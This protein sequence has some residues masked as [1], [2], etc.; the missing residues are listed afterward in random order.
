M[1][2][3]RTRGDFATIAGK[4]AA[5]EE[6]AQEQ[7]RTLSPDHRREETHVMTEQI[8][9]RASDS[10]RARSGPSSARK[11]RAAGS[12]TADDPVFGAYIRDVSRHGLLTAEQERRMGRQLVECR[13]GYWREVLSYPPFVEAA[14]DLL[15]GLEDMDCPPEVLETFG[16]LREA[17]RGVRGSNRREAREGFE[18][19]L[20]EAAGRLAMLDTEC[21]GADRIA[22]DLELVEAGERRG[23]SMRVRLPRKGSRPFLEYVGRVRRAATALRLKRNEFARANLRLVIRIATRFKS[24]G[25][26]LQ[27]R[28]QEGNLG[29]MKAI[30]RFDPT[31][32][33]RFSTYGSWWIRHAIR[34]AVVNRGR[35]IRLPAHLQAL[36]ARLAKTRRELR[37]ALQRDPTT[38]ELAEAVDTPIEKVELVLDAMQLRPVSLD[39]RM[40]E[41]DDRSVGELLA[42]EVDRQPGEQLDLDEATQRLRGTLLTLAPMEQ[43]ILR[44]RFGLDGS[45]TRTLAEIGTQYSLSRER[46][47]QLQQKALNRV[48]KRL[49]T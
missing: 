44:Q 22:A 2:R 21:V 40:G 5:E 20:E 26:S 34:R 49:R 11:K 14:L 47:R 46:I 42:A 19:A 6:E 7:E 15:E 27:D 18:S 12:G 17:T 23:L 48:R 36:W 38:A 41:H 28:V 45:E 31:R 8:Q 25:L 4:I 10:V 16:T 39:A 9:A 1:T 24:S 3:R 13:K 32:G 35:T 29:L 30:D 43:D 37:N 33:F